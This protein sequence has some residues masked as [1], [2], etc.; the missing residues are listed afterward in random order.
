M[1][2][3]IDYADISKYMLTSDNK[4]RKYY[5]SKYCFINNIPV[6]ISKYVHDDNIIP[7]CLCNHELM[8][9]NNSTYF[10]HMHKIDLNHHIIS[11]VRSSILGYCINIL[12]VTDV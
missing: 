4:C 1:Q 9:N 6:H 10:I 5:I 11:N 3:S 7:I 12:S 2:S 8:L